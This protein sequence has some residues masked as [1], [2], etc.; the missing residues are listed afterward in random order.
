PQ[1]QQ[2]D[3][4]RSRAREVASRHRDA[5][6]PAA[7]SAAGQRRRPGRARRSRPR[8]APRDDRA[9]GARR[10]GGDQAMRLAD[11]SIER[12]VLASVMVGVLLVFGLAAYPRI[13]VDLFPSVEFP[14]VTVTAVYPGADPE[15]VESKVVDKI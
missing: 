11:V 4:E 9:G 15:A 2:D 3:G 14:V 6:A 8:A 5:G 10:Q 7:G 1:R 13:G 12:P